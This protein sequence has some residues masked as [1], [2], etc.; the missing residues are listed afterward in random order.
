L[1]ALRQRYSIDIPQVVKILASFDKGPGVVFAVVGNGTKIKYRLYK[2]WP[3]NDSL[4]KSAF[5]KKENGYK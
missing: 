2:S 3:G 4:R 5:I 1:T